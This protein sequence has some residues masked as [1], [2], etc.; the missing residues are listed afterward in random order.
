MHAVA[1]VA[2]MLVI[3]SSVETC[4]DNSGTSFMLMFLETMPT[5]ASMQLLVT[6]PSHD[7][8]AM[9]TLRSPL[10]DDATYD[11]QPRDS[12][13]INAPRELRAMGNVISTSGFMLTSSIDVT[14]H[15]F[16]GDN[17]AC[18]GFMAIPVDRLG[19]EYYTLSRFRFDQDD[20][21][22][23]GVVATQDNTTVFIQLRF[24]FEAVGFEY[25]GV[26]YR[27]GTENDE[28]TVTLNAFE[29]I[30][31]VAL[32]ADNG[33]LSR[34]RIIADKPVAVF[35][36]NIQTSIDGSSADHMIE[37]MLPVDAAG[38]VFNLIELSGREMERFTVLA[39]ESGT[40]FT[41]GRDEREISLFHIGD[42]VLES[43]TQIR[44]TG[45]L[46]VVRHS[47]GENDNSVYLRGEPALLSVTP[48]ARYKNVHS[49]RVPTSDSVDY[50]VQLIIATGDVTL[51]QLATIFVDDSNIELSEWNT[52]EA[53]QGNRYGTTMH[54][55]PGFHRVYSTDPNVKLSVS[56]YGYVDQGCAFA[57]PAG[58]CLDYE[59]M[60]SA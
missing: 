40:T 44:A 16:N 11:V 10:T 24:V 18:G 58:M 6:N 14:V 56:V 50:A 59:P 33:D 35:T 17:G 7:T 23:F 51:A 55:D 25:E 4:N 34:T 47:V 27:S 53:L 15:G 30:Q 45:D 12:L 22:E 13:V 26:T 52:V 36:G 21:S 54:V 60:V 31:L 19:Y 1:A 29:S 5:N 41:R 37:Q 39:I 48:E 57:Y 3:V 28:L 42:L 2:L 8:V 49:F 20:R 32:P 43:S 46:F 38:R 9:V